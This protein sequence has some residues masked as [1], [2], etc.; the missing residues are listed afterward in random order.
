M[1]VPPQMMT[2]TMGMNNT[3][4]GV[5]ANAGGAANI[6]GT[7]GDISTALGLGANIYGISNSINLMQE[8]QTAF[9]QSNPMGAYRPTYAADLLNLIQNPSSVTSL[10]GYQFQMGQGV[11]A[12]D[13][14][15]AAPGGTGFGSG[16]EGAALA[17]FGQGLASNFY[18]QQVGVLGNLAGAGISPT[19]MTGAIQAQGGAASGFGSNIAGLGNNLGNAYNTVSGWMNP[20]STSSL[21]WGGTYS[22]L[23]S[24]TGALA[25]SQGADISSG[26]DA[27]ISGASAAGGAASDVGDLSD[28]FGFSAA[29]G[30][31][32]TGGAAA[33]GGTLGGSLATPGV[34]GS[35]AAPGAA[36]GTE[37]GGDVAVASDAGAAAGGTDAAAGLGGAAAGALFGGIAI[38]GIIGMGLLDAKQSEVSPVSLYN[39]NM[40]DAA[41]LAQISGN[42]SAGRAGPYGSSLVYL[43]DGSSPAMDALTQGAGP[44]MADIRGANSGVTPL[45]PQQVA[46]S[47]AQESTSYKNL[48]QYDLAN[49]IWG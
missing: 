20:V 21:D 34:V 23:D 49:N 26:I 31:A 43:G 36:A 3:G 37:V 25:A 46:A 15:A 33:G 32:A 40:N 24:S 1:S 6:G 5:V 18:N 13:R 19:G 4:T 9:N 30:E 11:Q 2:G 44:T 10:P 22:G 28:L 48:A 39:M 14:S 42:I 45:T 47:L 7:G 16:A 41:S 8:A 17:Q 38:G 29:G 35:L 27:G 12:I